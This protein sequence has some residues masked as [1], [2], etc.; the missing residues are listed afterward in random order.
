MYNSRSCYFQSTN[1]RNYIV[2]VGVVISVVG[3]GVVVD[4]VVGVSVV[5]G[6]VIG[7]ARNSLRCYTSTN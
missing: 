5:I 7:V 1:K 3:A 4:I 6:V 2:G